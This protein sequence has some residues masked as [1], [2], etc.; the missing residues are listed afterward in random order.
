VRALAP[1]L[2]VAATEEASVAEALD[3]VERNRASEGWQ[4]GPVLAAA[5]AAAGTTAVRTGRRPLP[6]AT[7]E[8][9]WR[10]GA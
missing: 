5:D 4:A 1:E 6:R 7:S 2:R 3:F 8:P 10:A 9:G